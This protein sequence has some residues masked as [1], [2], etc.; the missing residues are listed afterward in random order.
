MPQLLVTINDQ[1]KVSNLR[2]V[3][4]SLYGVDQVSVPRRKKGTQ[5]P[6]I[7]ST[8]KKQ[9]ARLEKLAKQKQNWDDEDAPFVS[10]RCVGSGRKAWQRRCYLSA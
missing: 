7:D 3:I 6:Q 4:K 5:E 2:R 10:T 8:Q 1:S 9:L